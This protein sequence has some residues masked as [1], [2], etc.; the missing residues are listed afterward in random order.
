LIVTQK[1]IDEIRGART[2]RRVLHLPVRY[3]AFGERKRCPVRA[4]SAYEL[5]PSIPHG[6]Y[7]TDAERQPSRAR[8]VLWL[9]DQCERP[10]RTVVVTVL[11]APVILEIDG[12]AVWVVH[13]AKGDQ[14]GLVDK[15]R[16][17][18]ARSGTSLGDYTS[19]P[20]RSMR[21]E[22]AAVPVDYQEQLNKEAADRSAGD[23]WE[24]IHGPAERIAS[25]LPAM[26]SN[27]SELRATLARRPDSHLK[28]EVERIERAVALME[29]ALQQ[30]R[31]RLAA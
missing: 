30:L 6:S 26:R 27:L 17:L 24:P 21:G 12:R 19:I 9:I 11:T 8:A 29:K 25:E 16:L 7:K 13:F 28:R 1:E 18:A 15:P 14:T 2:R 22:K 31:D 3:G 4:G 5:R 10:A 23:H 20:S